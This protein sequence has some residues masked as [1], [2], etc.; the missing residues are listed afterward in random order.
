MTPLPLLE[1]GDPRFAGTGL[2]IA[3]VL[4][5]WPGT[6]WLEPVCWYLPVIQKQRWILPFEIK[7]KLSKTNYP[8]LSV[9][10]RQTFLRGSCQFES[11]AM[12]ERRVAF[13]VVNPKLRPLTPPPYPWEKAAKTVGWGTSARGGRSLGKMASFWVTK[14]QNPP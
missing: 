14:K 10:L 8:V 9:S 3:L 5:L 13:R 7:K 4:V 11:L 12:L 2:K 1:D 6:T